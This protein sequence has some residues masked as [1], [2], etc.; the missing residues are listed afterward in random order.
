MADSHV[1]RHDHERRPLDHDD[2]LVRPGHFEDP[3]RRETAMPI[4]NPPRTFSHSRRRR[5]LRSAG[6][7][8][9]LL[10]AHPGAAF[11]ETDGQATIEAKELV[12]R[13]ADGTAPL[14]L[15]VRTPA[16]F[17]K[18]HIPGAVLIPH[19]VLAERLAELPQDRR[20]EIV[21]YCQSGRRAGQ[22]EAVLAASGY[23]HVRDLEGHW[24]AWSRASHPSETAAP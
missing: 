21:V 2:G 6:F 5:A 14:I 17:A 19:D 4:T 23:E 22:A 18:G 15:D 11:A 1:A 24:K 9:M 13:L 12:T 10:L 7:S 20:R 8:A 16:E 3:F